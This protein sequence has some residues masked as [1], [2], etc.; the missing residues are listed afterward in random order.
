MTSLELP[1]QHGASRPQAHSDK[2]SELSWA[3]C[4]PT[5]AFACRSSVM[6]ELSYFTSCKSDMCPF[7]NHIE[8]NNSWVAPI[9]YRDAVG[10]PTPQNSCTRPRNW[11]PHIVAVHPLKRRI[12]NSQSFN[13]THATATLRTWSLPLNTQAHLEHGHV[14]RWQIFWRAKFRL[15][16]PRSPDCMHIWNSACA[17]L[18]QKLSGLGL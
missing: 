18:G 7:R 5:H 14:H 11:L 2:D 4:H 3:S 15:D 1:T 9:V 17:S 8:R 16:G 6:Q 12:F 10:P 13:S